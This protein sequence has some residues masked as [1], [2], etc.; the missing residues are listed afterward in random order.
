MYTRGGAS[1]A[2][3]EFCLPQFCLI[4]KEGN[5]IILK[6]NWVPLGKMNA[7]QQDRYSLQCICPTS[8]H[9]LAFPYFGKMTIYNYSFFRFYLFMFRE[10]GEERESEG[11]KHQ[12]VITP[13]VPPTAD[14]THNP[15]MCPDWESNWCPF[16]LQ[17]GTQST[18]PHHPEHDYSLCKQKCIH[19]SWKRDLKF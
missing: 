7:Y 4:Q 19:L 5:C 10:R 3:L 17:A 2:I 16:S 8:I 12:C 1:W 11:E 9:I 18:E 14:L 6:G 13:H 15:G